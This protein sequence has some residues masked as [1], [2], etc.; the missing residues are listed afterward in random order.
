[1]G[2]KY[3]LNQAGNKMGMNP[4]ASNER[5]VLLRF[6][7][8]AAR[9]LYPQSDMVGSLME[10][11]FKINGDQTIAF[12]EYL[13][14]LRA[15][16]SYDTHV[17]IHINQMRPRYNVVN[18]ADMWRNYRIKNKQTLHTSVVNQ[19]QIV[20][21]VYAVEDPPVQV[22][23][24]GPTDF[25]DNAIEIVVMDAISKTSTNVFND[26]T[27][28]V[29]DRVNNYN[30]IASDIDGNQVAMIPNNQLE[31]SYLIVDIS[32]FPYLNNDGGSTQAHYMEVLYKKR[33]TIL[34]DDADVFPAKNFDDILVNKMMQLWAEEQEKTELALAYDTKAT[35]SMAR[36]QEE[37]NRATEDCIALVPVGADEILAKIRVNRPKWWPTARAT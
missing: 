19:A 17:P 8:E 11:L 15:A 28:L 7:N 4:S 37:E 24:S 34:S 6:L 9:E 25:S 20:L 5:S 10:Q 26:V 30:V 14:E 32:E 33:L 36:L 35:R 13:G 22:T 16:R 29:K 1:M 12:P 31:T 18:W 23:I 27:M 2:V 3:I 21:S